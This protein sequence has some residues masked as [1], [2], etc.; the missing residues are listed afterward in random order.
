MS[1]PVITGGR[2]AKN[3]W[4]AGKIKCGRCGAGLMFMNSPT[5]V[6]YFR[7]RKRAD[8]KTCDGCGTIRTRELEEFVYSKMFERMGEFQ[9]LSNHGNVK[10]NPKL[11]SYKVELLQ[12]EAEIDKLLE[13]LSGANATLL[14]YANI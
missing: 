7:C 9:T 10:A 2:K 5:N 3:T 6:S 4:L 13:T 11:T 12:I 8:N 14:S 1:N